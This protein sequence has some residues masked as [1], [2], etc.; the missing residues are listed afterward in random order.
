MGYTIRAKKLDILSKTLFS[1]LFQSILIPQFIKEE[2][3][4]ICLSSLKTPLYLVE[5]RERVSRIFV[6]IQGKHPNSLPAIFLLC[7]Q[8]SLTDH[9]NTDGLY[10]KI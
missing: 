8:A 1:I 2:D 10:N 9:W 3:S 5:C 7:L 6:I 4:L